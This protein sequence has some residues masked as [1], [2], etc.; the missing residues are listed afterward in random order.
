MFQA[1]VAYLPADDIE[2]NQANYH[3]QKAR[4][5]VYRYKQVYKQFQHLS[6]QAHQVKGSGK[7]KVVRN[8]FYDDCRHVEVV[9]PYSYHNLYVYVAFAYKA[10]EV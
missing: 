4:D 7:V 5:K 10:D 9:R 3:P 2:N 1:A 8:S 6:V